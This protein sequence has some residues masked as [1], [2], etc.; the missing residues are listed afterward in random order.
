LT[1]IQFSNNFKKEKKCTPT[2]TQVTKPHSN[3]Q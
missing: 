1:I 3:R 2:N